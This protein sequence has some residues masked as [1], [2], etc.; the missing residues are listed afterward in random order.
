MALRD[1]IQRLAVGHRFYGYRRIA[2]LVQRE[3]YEVGTK[4]VRRWM[5]E[6][7]L[8]AVRRRKFVATTDSDHDFVVYPNL[9]EQLMVSDVNQLWVPS[10][11]AQGEKQTTIK[12]KCC[13]RSDSPYN[14][15]MVRPRGRKAKQLAGNRECQNSGLSQKRAQPKPCQN[16]VQTRRVG[17]RGVSFERKADSP[18]R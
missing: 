11:A 3:G 12:H 15:L 2:I 13:R 16:R 18:N 5:K 6:D 10:N 1:V 4:K 8:L 17:A 9:A 7:N 14:A